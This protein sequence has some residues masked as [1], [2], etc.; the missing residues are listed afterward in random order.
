MDKRPDPDKLLEQIQAEVSKKG[1]LKI[2][3][4]AVAGVG[5]TYA[6]LEDAGH[7]KKEGVDVVIGIVETHKRPETEVLLEGLEIIPLKSVSY[8]NIEVKEFDLEAALKR[9]PALILVDELAHSNAPGSRH[10][11]RW[12]DVEELLDAGISVY[13]TL[14]VQHCESVNDI[15]AQI[16]KVIVRETVPDTFVE[17][18][19]E[20]ELI[21]IPTEELLKRLREGKVYLGEQAELAAWNFFRFGNLIALRQLA[22]KYTSRSV[23]TRLRLFKDIHAIST[24]WKVG[25]HFLVCIS[26]NPR[27]AKIIRAAK[28]IASDLGAQW[29][30][31]HVERPLAFEQNAEDKGQVAEMLHFAEKMGASTVTLS[32]EDVAETLISYARSKNIS[33]III[34]KPG[35]PSL[36]ETLFGSFID[37]LT[38]KCGEIDLYLISGESEEE[39]PKTQYVPAKSFSWKG[40]LWAVFTIG[41]CT[42]ID[43]L[44]FS[45]LA[46]ANLIMVYLLGVAWLAFR[47]G[48]HISIIGTLLSIVSFD[49]FFIPPFYSFSVMDKEHLI[50]FGVMLVVGLIIGSLTGRLRRQT[51]ELRLREEKTRVLYSLSRDLAKSSRP[52][53]LFQIFLSHIQDFFKCPAAILVA[54]STKR[55]LTILTAISYGRELATKELAV[56]SWVYEHR[57]I[58]GKGTDTFSG[59]EGLYVPLTGSQEIVGVLGVFPSDEEKFLSPDNF[60]TLEMFVSQTALAVEGAW[61]AEANIRAESELG[62]NRIRNMLLDTATYDVRGALDVISKS[63]SELLK[64]EMLADETI[65]NS[66]IKEI[67]RQAEQLDN[68]AVELPKIIDELKQN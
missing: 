17:K 51:I 47:Y 58:A 19:D 35:K 50:T 62:R 49:F 27:A 59:S 3:F 22:L 2:F 56:A 41:L 60:H 1:R 18:A 20:I 12:Q 40:V 33:R 29:T 54:D 63:A 28:Q 23:D 67:I 52:D 42:A 15:V 16:T 10:T 26:S 8:R 14:N 7:R 57:K 21:D 61:L 43:K 53:E 36:R 11:K 6:M 34:G 65:R 39:P 68:L 9:R 45:Y 55:A 4:G 5:K 66:L 32:G 24:V 25:E 48:R 30:V 38:R 46:L 44:L 13:T 31:V 64:Q 37:K